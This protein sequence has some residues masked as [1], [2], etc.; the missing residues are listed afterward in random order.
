MICPRAG[1]AP[2]VTGCPEAKTYCHDNFRYCA[3][4]HLIRYDVFR[5]HRGPQ[6]ALNL[7]VAYASG[8]VVVDTFS[9]VKG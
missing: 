9:A 1:A 5:E 4:K 2:I 8:L 3:R 6:L 7:A